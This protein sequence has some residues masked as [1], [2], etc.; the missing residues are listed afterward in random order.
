MNCVET[1]DHGIGLVSGELQLSDGTVLVVDETTIQEGKIDNTGIY[2]NS[3]IYFFIYLFI[4]L[5]NNFLYNIL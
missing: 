3:F 5:N 2:I 4:Y 1:L